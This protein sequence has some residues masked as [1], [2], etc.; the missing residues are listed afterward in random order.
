MKTNE[1]GTERSGPEKVASRYNM[2]SK[3][4]MPKIAGRIFLEAGGGWILEEERGAKLEAKDKLRK[5]RRAS[6]KLRKK[7]RASVHLELW[8]SVSLA[9]AQPPSANITER[10]SAGVLFVGRQISGRQ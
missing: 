4:V 2:D 5:K 8:S 10:G 9:L 3:L 7:R 6:V 1:R